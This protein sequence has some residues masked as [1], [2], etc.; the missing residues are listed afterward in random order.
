[1]P[2]SPALYPL[3]LAWMQALTA[4][5]PAHPAAVSALAHL[6]TALLVGQSL[7]PPP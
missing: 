6:V 2:S 7:R 1:M 5:T 4:G 3:V